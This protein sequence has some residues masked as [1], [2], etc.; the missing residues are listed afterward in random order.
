[1]AGIGRAQS[2]YVPREPRSSK[3]GR[4]DSTPETSLNVQLPLSTTSSAGGAASKAGKPTPRWGKKQNRKLSMKETKSKSKGANIAVVEEPDVSYFEIGNLNVT[5][6]EA[7]GLELGPEHNS[8]PLNLYVAVKYEDQSYDTRVSP[9]TRNP[10][11]DQSFAFGVTDDKFKKPIV[12]TV[13]NRASPHDQVVGVHN[14]YLHEKDVRYG[15]I[16]DDFLR[17][18]DEKKKIELPR[19][20][21]RVRIEFTQK[22]SRLDPARDERFNVLPP[23]HQRS[24]D[25]YQRNVSKKSSG[26]QV[27]ATKIRKEIARD[28]DL[29]FDEYKNIF[30]D[31]FRDYINSQKMTDLELQNLDKKYWSKGQARGDY[32][33]FR[34]NPLEAKKRKRSRIIGKSLS[35]QNIL[36]AINTKKTPSEMRLLQDC[37]DPK[38]AM[39]NGMGIVSV[40]IHSAKNLVAADSVKLGSIMGFGGTTEKTESD[41]FVQVF[42]YPRGV[43]QN[44]FDPNMRD[45]H[46]V[47]VATTNTEYKVL[48][49]NF[50]T[51]E[52]KDMF[53]EQTKLKEYFRLGCFENETFGSNLRGKYT[54]QKMTYK[55]EKRIPIG[56]GTEAPGNDTIVVQNSPHKQMK[57]TANGLDVVDGQLYGAYCEIPFMVNGSAHPVQGE[58][59]GKGQVST[60]PWKEVNATEYIRLH[61]PK[62]VGDMNSSLEW[63]EHPGQL[64]FEVYDDDDHERWAQTDK[65]SA[66]RNRTLS[67][68]D[69]LGCCIFEMRDL[70]SKK[71]DGSEGKLRVITQE[72]PLKI[73]GGSIDFRPEDLQKSLKEQ[74]EELKAHR[75]SNLGLLKVSFQLELGR[76]KKADAFAKTGKTKMLME[77]MKSERNRKVNMTPYFRNICESESV[78]PF[79]RGNKSDPDGEF[80]AEVNAVAG[81]SRATLYHLFSSIK[82]K[83]ISLNHYKDKHRDM[84]LAFMGTYYNDYLKV[85]NTHVIAKL[86][87][88]VKEGF[89][90]VMKRSNWA[91]LTNQWNNIAPPDFTCVTI[92]LNQEE[93]ARTA[94]KDSKFSLANPQWNE[95]FQLALTNLNTPEIELKVLSK[96]KRGKEKVLGKVKI[97]LHHVYNGQWEIYENAEPPKCMVTNRLPT[98]YIKE[99]K[100]KKM[101]HPELDHS[102]EQEKEDKKND[103]LSEDQKAMIKALGIALVGKDQKYDNYQHM[104]SKLCKE[105]RELKDALEDAKFDV[106]DNMLDHANGLLEGNFYVQYRKTQYRKYPGTPFP[107]L[108]LLE[109][110]STLQGV[111]NSEEYYLLRGV[112]SKLEHSLDGWY[113]LYDPE[114]SEDDKKDKK[115][116]CAGYLRVEMK[117]TD[118]DKGKKSRSG[119]VTVGKTS[120]GPQALK[121]DETEVDLYSVLYGS[122]KE[123]KKRLKAFKKTQSSEHRTFEQFW[124]ISFAEEVQ[125]KMNATYGKLLDSEK[126]MHS[127]VIDAAKHLHS[128]YEFDRRTKH[129]NN[130][131]DRI[132]MNIEGFEGLLG[133]TNDFNFNQDT[134]DRAWHERFLRITVSGKEEQQTHS[135]EKEL[136]RAILSVPCTVSVP[137]KETVVDEKLLDTVS[138]PNDANRNATI[139]EAV[140][141]NWNGIKVAMKAHNFNKQPFSLRNIMDALQ[142]EA[143]KGG[144]EENLGRL[145]DDKKQREISP[146]YEFS[147]FDES[148]VIKIEVV[149]RTQERVKQGSAKK[150][151][152]VQTI[153]GPKNEFV[154]NEAIWSPPTREVIVGCA[155]ISMKELKKH[156]KQYCTEEGLIMGRHIT[157]VTKPS[158]FS[159][160]SKMLLRPGYEVLV[161]LQKVRNNPKLPASVPGIVTGVRT[162]SGGTTYEVYIPKISVYSPYSTWF[163]MGQDMS[164]LSVTSMQLKRHL[165]REPTGRVK[166]NIVVLDPQKDVLPVTVEGAK[167]ISESQCRKLMEDVRETKNTMRYLLNQHAPFSRRIKNIFHN[168]LHGS[169]NGYQNLDDKPFPAVVQVQVL[170]ARNFYTPDSV[171]KANLFPY[172]Q[173]VPS[174]GVRNVTGVNSNFGFGKARD[175]TNFK[176]GTFRPNCIKW[177]EK[178]TKWYD[179]VFTFEV[180]DARFS[181]LHLRLRDALKKVDDDE[182][183]RSAET[184]S[185]EAVDDTFFGNVS[186]DLR[187]VLE[188]LL[189]ELEKTTSGPRR[190]FQD[191]KKAEL[192]REKDIREKVIRRIDR[193]IGDEDVE[194]CFKKGKIFEKASKKG[195]AIHKEMEKA[196]NL[197][198]HTNE[199][200]IVGDKGTV[201]N[202]IVINQWYPLSGLKDSHQEKLNK[203]AVQ[204]KVKLI[205]KTVSE[206]GALTE[207][208]SASEISAILKSVEAQFEHMRLQL[209]D[210]ST[211]RDKELHDLYVLKE[212]KNR[213]KRNDLRTD[214]KLDRKDQLV[215]GKEE[216]PLILSAKVLGSES[217]IKQLKKEIQE[218]DFKLKEAKYEEKTIKD[219]VEFNNLPIPTK[220]LKNGAATA[221]NKTSKKINDGVTAVGN[222]IKPVV[223]PVVTSWKWVRSMIWGKEAEEEFE[224]ETNP[225]EAASF[226][227]YDKRKYKY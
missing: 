100:T 187:D 19:S 148:M 114:N 86:D 9:G 146:W 97:D 128:M 156:V 37:R 111:K 158:S 52:H 107:I 131:S 40:A 4:A 160:D 165:K 115:L 20:E 211:K 48:S 119:A 6:V 22:G 194:K 204:V 178:E 89:N 99:L 58:V 92:L 90:I 24:D 70:L 225:L 61:I 16:R 184:R 166:L 12:M 87:I 84:A 198:E 96:N 182:L 33:Q 130:K 196:L 193:L 142:K 181:K 8:S 197:A 201:N 63:S 214:N 65:I 122:S 49:P 129:Y 124:A 199:G 31:D 135:S 191:A 202:S 77:V 78:P 219:D 56:V 32:T 101:N 3:L 116:R 210:L 108:P 190:K 144:S 103:E 174:S 53:N 57:K 175:R 177:N 217:R 207:F 208:F 10:K 42:Y 171:K 140:E 195:I 28:R 94:W 136:Q 157:S 222:K 152:T 188:V 102:S 69:F 139:R 62:P 67:N 209:Q 113:N 163:E 223:Q 153:H 143:E 2:E 76:K 227:Q 141:S 79:M 27:H 186:I 1:M 121:G 118:V 59:L 218:L 106:H 13:F 95:N 66:L 83:E 120:R 220:D 11:Y 154:Q 125:K 21:L 151:V 200:D 81:R 38:M 213:K 173:V 80:Y 105:D 155:S 161:N 192:H 29:L 39:S 134:G 226:D 179:E 206:S 216:E 26:D 180:S 14:V 117:W 145:S 132:V 93:V 170:S 212:N 221:V 35:R 43:C 17:L 110:R 25:T 44:A 126:K 137:G 74:D 30:R 23:S 224:P 72:I 64:V 68:N 133:P 150:I 71:E 167:E 203:G 15:K 41:P 147:F 205:L 73:R 162:N 185:I 60:V 7:R 5:V 47:E 109:P 159:M 85:T 45:Y 51:N 104:L 88:S 91:S 168:D 112:G 149:D 98:E 75:S 123:A 183:Q 82:N 46:P 215:Y 18:R 54:Q 169:K 176:A 34:H 55:C 164:G 189:E 36:S 138:Q 50:G 127:D 172:V